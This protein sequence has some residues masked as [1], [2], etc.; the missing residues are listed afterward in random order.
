V[1]RRTV[2]VVL[3]VNEEN[4]LRG[5]RAYRDAHRAEAER[6]VALLESDIG[7]GL[8]RTPDDF[9]LQG[10]RPT[11]PELLDWLAADFVET[12]WDMK[13][14]IKQL[15]LSATYKQSSEH[16]AGSSK[17]ADEIDPENKLLSRAPRY[18]LPAW[19][20]RD[21]ALQAAGLLNPAL[22]GPPVKPYQPDGVWEENFMGRFHYEPSEGPEQYRRTVY[23]FWRRSVAP[24]F[25]F[26]SAQRRTCEVKPSRT[27]TP[28]HALTLLNDETMLEC[29]RVLAEKAMR[30]SKTDAGRIRHMALCVLSR[31]PS[32]QEA[33]V[34]GEKLAHARR[35]YTDHV[36][37]AQSFLKHGQAPQGK[38]ISVSDLAATTLVASMI[39]N[40]DEAM[41]R[42]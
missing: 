22:G 15:V 33:E 11:H 42:E 7:N 5:G 10:E 3:W 13:R 26:D 24:T 1:P 19:M 16:E 4:G 27:N 25:L 38:D 28:L 35:Y 29:S 20:I 12:H 36:A 40:L 9:G 34:L 37:D 18:R 2:R 32:A 39:L 31:E 8:V 30:A 6:H 41:T 14:L 17:L 23:A 21:S